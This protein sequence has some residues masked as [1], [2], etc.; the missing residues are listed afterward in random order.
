M[1]A[2]GGLIYKKTRGFSEEAKKSLHNLNIKLNNDD[3]V[4]NVLL[5]IA[6]GNHLVVKK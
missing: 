1:F 4:T 5:D 3:R 2:G 6:D